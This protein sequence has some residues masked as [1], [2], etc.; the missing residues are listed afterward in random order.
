MQVDRILYP[1]KTLGPGNRIGIWTLGCSKQCSRCINPELWQNQANKNVPV[2]ELLRFVREVMKNNVVDGITI[3]GGDPLEQANDVLSFIYEINGECGDILIYTGYTFSELCN[4]WSKH[5]IDSLT[6]NT[7]V[8]IDGRYIDG[9][10]DNR[11]P[12]IGST[13]QTIH[14]FDSG[15]KSK[16]EEYMFLNG[17]QIQNIYYENE[18]FSVGIHNIERGDCDGTTR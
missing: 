1:V 6:E 18:L 10:N 3:S 17:R 11:S 5:Q 13:N 2:P 4:L 8:L 15:L 9:L 16:Y 12:L 14:Y 7:A